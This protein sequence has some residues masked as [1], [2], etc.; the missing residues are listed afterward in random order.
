MRRCFIL[1]CI[2]RSLLLRASTVSSVLFLASTILLTVLFLLGHRSAIKRELQLRA[3]NKAI[4]LAAQSQFAFLV[5]DTAE[6]KRLAEMMARIDDVAWVEFRDSTRSIRQTS[7]EGKVEPS[8]SLFTEASQFVEA[9][10]AGDLVEWE[11]KK[12]SRSIGEVRIALTGRTQQD[13][14]TQMAWRAAAVVALSLVLI[15]TLLFVQL[16]KL[17]APLRNLTRATQEVGRG[18]LAH[19]A[20]VEGLDEVSE[21]AQAF[22]TMTDRLGKTTVSKT[23]L[24]D[25]IQSMGESLLVVNNKGNVTQI[26]EAL[27]KL[28]GCTRDEVISAPLQKLLPEFPL[29]H[30]G[31]FETYFRR[32]DGGRVDALISVATLSPGEGGER[33]WVLVGQDLTERKRTECQLIRAKEAAEAADKAKSAFLAN[34]THE[35]RTPLNS[36]IGFA[37]LVQEELEDRGLHELLPDV[38]KV[39]NAARH[40]LGI[41]NEVLDLSKIEAGRMEVYKEV[42]SLREAAR[43]V[44][45][46]AEPLA[47]KNGNRL[48]LEEWKGPA[49]VEN[50]EQKFRQSLL[51]LLSNACKFTRDG[52]VTVSVAHRTDGGHNLYE[53][54]VRDTG[55]G[56]S[57]QDIGR[58]FQPFVQVDSSAGRRFGGSGLGLAISRRFCQMM[59]GD[60]RVESEPG[61]GSTFTMIIPAIAKGFS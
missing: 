27:L 55:I 13:L 57:S 42:F 1:N 51:N 32:S 58:L 11:R 15:P 8:G 23:Y 49:L 25:I 44:V 29:D 45:Q 6:L 30:S 60:L 56:I 26:N 35:I 43:Q 40:L 10:T 16:K 28:A 2:R 19:R 47:A 36:V 4:F 31:T 3:N 14:F 24:D 21:L 59:G 50:D 22:N 48:L 52:I 61:Q 18:N 41:V 38:E 39:T 37:G 46:T 9:P 54:N 7:A 17:L 34:M 53:V 20:D 12:G 33:A 5:G